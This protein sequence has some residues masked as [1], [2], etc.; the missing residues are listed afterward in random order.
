MI[1]SELVARLA[2]RHPHLYLRDVE[3]AVSAVFEQM[4]AAMARGDR[5]EIRGFGSFS[6]RLREAKVGRNPAAGDHVDVGEKVFPHFRAG[7]QL[8]QRLNSVTNSERD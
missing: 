4:A 3:R 2:K 6:V 5:V 1:K 8:H 7:K